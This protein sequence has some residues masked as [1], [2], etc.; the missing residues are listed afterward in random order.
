MPEEIN[1]ILTDSIAD[2]LF[3]TEDDG[4][5]NLENEGIG[6]GKVFF[7]GNIM[8]DS[9]VN[10]KNKIAY[11]NILRELNLNAKQYIYYA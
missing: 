8:I 7:V 10:Y 5:K 3:V 4:I 2:Y 9:L 11:S 6:N 1:R